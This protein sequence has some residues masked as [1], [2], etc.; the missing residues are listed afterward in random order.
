M[1][2]NIGDSYEIILVDDGSSDGTWQAIRH[3]ATT[4]P[5]VVG[6]RLSKNFSHQSALIAGLSRARG[7]AVISMDSDLQHP[8]EAIPELLEAWRAGFKIVN[9][10]RRDAHVASP[11]KRLASKLFYRFFTV[12]TGISMEEGT[13]DF[14][15]LDHRA[16][17]ELLTFASTDQFIRGSVQ[18]LG[19]SM[20]TIPYNAAK[21]LTGQSKYGLKNMLRFAA[22]AI[23]SFSTKPLRFGIWLGLCVGAL[24][25]VELLYVL[26]Q[27][28][29]GNVVPGWASTVGV[30]SFL[31]AVMF[32]VIGIIGIYVARIYTLLQNRPPFIVAEHTNHEAQ[33]ESVGN[34]SRHRAKFR[35]TA[36]KIPT[37]N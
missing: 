24:A 1:L 34:S 13:S 2:G 6:L 5:S 4:N 23:T 33:D 36:G 18:W 37:V 12:M 35:R 25:L 22:I 30:T 16:L 21:R 19:F 28:L 15:L 26:V 11:S 9:T 17:T 32:I 29:S 14:R 27:A 20:T 8:P 7:Q 3:A 10:K 31:F